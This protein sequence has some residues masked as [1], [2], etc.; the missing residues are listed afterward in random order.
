MASVTVNEETKSKNAD[1]IFNLGVAYCSARAACCG[2]IRSRFPELES[3][4]LAHFPGVLYGERT[5]RD[6]GGPRAATVRVCLPA[7][8]ELIGAGD[9]PCGIMPP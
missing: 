9:A 1:F 3:L 6:R 2:R 5:P 7:S 8:S 4:G